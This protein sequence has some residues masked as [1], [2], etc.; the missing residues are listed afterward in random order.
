[1]ARRARITPKGYVYHV[2]NRAAGRREMFRKE[3]DYL[4]FE[5]VMVEAQERVPLR[6]LSW[7]LMSTHWHFVVWPRTDGEVTDF[8]R[9]L[10]HTHAMRWRVAHR[11]VG[12]GPL[13]QGRFKSFPVEREGHTVSVC[14]YVEGN[15]LSAGLVKRAE[16]WRW[17]SLWARREGSAEMRGLLAEWPAGRP[18]DWVGMVNRVMGEKE[19]ERVEV[20]MERGRP[21]GSEG[22]VKAVVKKLGMEHTVRGEGRPRKVVARERV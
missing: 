8:F 22:W 12:E 4:G 6:I 13:Y 20:S 2:L 5:R 17:S 9:W 10:A 14:R 21:Y 16:D 19:R 18:R 3:G 11:T 7:C 1:M 15:A